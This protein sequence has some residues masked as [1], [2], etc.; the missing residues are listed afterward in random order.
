M[1]SICCCWN[2]Y[3]AKLC[4]R[5]SCKTN[6]W[7]ELICWL[8]CMLCRT[9]G[10]CTVLQTR[11]AMVGIAKM[12]WSCRISGPVLRLQVKA[13]LCSVALYVIPI[14]QQTYF[15]FGSYHEIGIFPISQCLCRCEFWWIVL[16]NSKPALHDSYSY[17]KTQQEQGTSKDNWW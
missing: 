5:S 3:L 12:L 2:Q 15:C 6:P 10:Y 7:K 9:L 1:L 8:V 17:L 14:Y 4:P 11:L 13:M 16:Q